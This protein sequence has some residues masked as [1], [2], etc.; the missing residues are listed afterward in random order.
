MS[1][2]P[3]VRGMIGIDLAMQGFV[4]GLIMQTTGNLSPSTTGAESL[5]YELYQHAYCFCL[6][7]DIP[8][9]NRLD[10]M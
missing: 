2:F 9:R 3:F 6:N 10:S 4:A 7:H 8:P 5:R 1:L